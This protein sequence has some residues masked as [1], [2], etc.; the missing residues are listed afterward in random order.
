MS[1]NSDND[2]CSDIET[3][4]CDSDIGINAHQKVL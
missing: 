4:A 3:L 1:H 2:N